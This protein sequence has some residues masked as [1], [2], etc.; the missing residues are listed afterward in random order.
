MIAGP[1]ISGGAVKVGPAI[2]GSA[3]LKPELRHEKSVNAM[4]D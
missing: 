2:I 1:M 3:D 4:L